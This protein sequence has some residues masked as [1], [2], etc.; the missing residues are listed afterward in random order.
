MGD[1]MGEG[2]G[3][4]KSE[5]KEE[6]VLVVLVGARFQSKTKSGAGVS[7]LRPVLAFLT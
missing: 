7:D 4:K 5:R 1:G 6:M 3:R 2:D